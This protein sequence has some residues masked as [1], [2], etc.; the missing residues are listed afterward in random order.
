VSARKVS[1]WVLGDQLDEQH[2]G[3]RGRDPDGVRVLM[4]ESA[5]LLGGRRFHRQRL[6][7]VLAAMRRYAQALRARGFE[8]DYQRAPSFRA[9][10]ERHR[11]KYRPSQIVAAEPMSRGLQALLTQ[12]S[13]TLLRHDRF[14]C[15]YQDFERWARNEN[16]RV[17]RMD[18]FYRQRRHATGYLMEAGKPLAGVFSFDKENRKPPP[19]GA[20]SWMH[21]IARYSRSCPG[22]RSVPLPAACG[23]ARVRARCSD[24]S[25]S[26]ASCCRASVHTRTR[27][28]SARGIWRT[29]CSAR[30]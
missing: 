1:V 12:L 26:F 14:L 15:H 9:G 10:L 27:C 5:A 17:L 29:R 28:F 19:R 22:L 4:I 21:S 6:H 20:T 24:S 2:P 13:V 3:L 25:T 7:M 16:E 11:A 8:V 23:P 30:I 18:H